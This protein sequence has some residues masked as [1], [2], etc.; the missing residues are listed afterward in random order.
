MSTRHSLHQFTE[1]EIMMKNLVQDFAKQA[2]PWEL[3]Q[4]MDKESK[5][6]E[7][8]KGK[9][10]E[11]GLMGIEI[12][13]EYGGSGA[14]FTSSIIAIEELAK[15][16][17]AIS[18][19]VDV[20]NTLVNNLVKLYGNKQ[21]KDKYLPLLASNGMGSFCLS[22]SSSG[23]DAFALKTKAEPKSDGS[24]VLNGTKCWITSSLEASFYIVMANTDFSKGYK[25]I[26]AF[27]IDRSNPGVKIGKKE[28]K[29]GIRASSTCEVIL[30]DCHV[31]PEAVLG[32]VG[33]GYKI[34]IET[35]NEG[36]IGIGK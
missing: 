22:E 33:K 36:R 14:S 11:S 3:V 23:S 6:D 26:T 16:D 25:G 29:L 27:L 18:V 10:F 21:Q 30:E 4:R 28:D 20:Q 31:G 19:V 13:E 32:G 12:P 17:P 24:Y 2:M 15:V 34:A 1:D 7:T 35:L 5:L 8:L 9:L